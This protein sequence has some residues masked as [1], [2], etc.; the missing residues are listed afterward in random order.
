[1]WLKGKKL[2]TRSEYCNGKML[3]PA[4]I[5][6]TKLPCVST[7]PFGTPDVPDVYMMVKTSSSFISFLRISSDSIW[8]LL[9]F[10]K[11]SGS[12]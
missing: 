1:M 7:A 4:W 11:E 5:L 9:A 10:L 6:L 2:K 3:I 8:F 12:K